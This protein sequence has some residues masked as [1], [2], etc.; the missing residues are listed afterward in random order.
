VVELGWCGEPCQSAQIAEVD[1]PTT[2]LPGHTFL[3]GMPC[4]ARTAVVALA[5]VGLGGVT[6]GGC[7]SSSDRPAERRSE[8]RARLVG[9]RAEQAEPLGVAVPGYAAAVVSDGRSAQGGQPDVVL[10]VSGSAAPP[11]GKALRPT[12]RFHVG[13]ITKT[14]TAALVLQLDQSG[15]LS[16]DD[17]V[18]RWI[19][20]PGGDAVTIEMLL[21][22]TSGIPDFTQ[23]DCSRDATSEQSIAL[24]AG[25]P[26]EFSP[27]T[28]WAYSNTNYTMLGLIADKA[29][30][31]SWADLVESRF[32][33]PLGL[34]DTYVWTGDAEGPT[35]SG[36]QLVCGEPSEPAC[37]PPQPGFEILPAEDGYDWSVAWS[38][39][40][41]V[42]TPADLAKWMTALV[43]GDVLDSAHRRLMTTPTRQSVASDFGQAVAELGEVSG[44]GTLRWVGDGLGLFVYEIGGVGTAW[45]HEGT[46]NG[47]VANAAFVE[48]TAQGIA[49]AS[50]LAESDSFSA[51]GAVAITASHWRSS[52]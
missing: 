11:G 20:V 44:G 38:A 16:I 23:F 51:L 37:A 34:D 36:A 30:S 35:V 9:L 15:E 8:L 12:D 18:S 26:F 45:G 43:G 33:E 42:S 27:G 24:V 39:G 52:D 40:A 19:D 32:F 41:V 49:A 28:S 25:Q 21:G 14:F 29:T 2:D 10:A 22:H 31:R 13:S 17:P 4:A 3:S 6:A 5:V 48:S 46:I 50:N 47:F 1:L 7:S